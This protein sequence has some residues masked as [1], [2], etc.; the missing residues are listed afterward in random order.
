MAAFLPIIVAVLA[1]IGLAI[2][3]PTNAALAR[4]SGSVLLAA[5]TSFVVG[6]LTLV[7]LWATL[8]RTAPAAMKGAPVWAW[9]GGFYGAGFVAA[10]AFA[11]PRLGVAT[12]LTM[13]IASQICTALVLDH[14]GLLGLRSAPVTP[15]K[16]AG[17]VLLL[18][19]VLL[20]RRG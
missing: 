17:V 1:G 18:G 19:G 11:A 8:D 16:L 6:L 3:A 5:G 15:G 20:I 12:T 2:Q 9:A 4:T 13:A 7:A 10:I 14:F